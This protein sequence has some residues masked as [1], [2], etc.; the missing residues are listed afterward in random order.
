MS[1][2]TIIPD[3]LK[4]RLVC[5][6]WNAA[7]STILKHKLF[8]YHISCLLYYDK[9]IYDE[10]SIKKLIV[11]RE[12]DEHWNA[13]QEKIIPMITTVYDDLLTDEHAS[14]VVE[15][16]LPIEFLMFLEVYREF[17]NN[18]IKLYSPTFMRTIASSQFTITRK[19]LIDGSDTSV[20]IHPLC[21]SEHHRC[22]MLDKQ[23]L[24]VMCYV[25]IM[26][27][28]LTCKKSRYDDADDERYFILVLEV[29]DFSDNVDKKLIE[30]ISVITQNVQSNIE[31]LED[32]DLQTFMKTIKIVAKS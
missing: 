18:K 12:L 16:Y 20:H 29:E 17:P 2:E 7:I 13:Y 10:N 6:K 30:K 9:G 25:N 5:K 19:M 23:Y 4:A 21:Y 26:T 14:M 1:V 31:Y 24:N 15:N 3:M 22:N 28:D 32:L 27:V 11:A 8:K